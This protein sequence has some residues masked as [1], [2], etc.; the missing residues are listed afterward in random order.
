ML[1]GYSSR[2]APALLLGLWF[3]MEVSHAF[4][5]EMKIVT[6]ADNCRAI[7][8]AAGGQ[9]RIELPQAGA[10]GYAWEIQDLDSEYFEL[11][12]AGTTGRPSP[13]DLV[14][15]PVTMQW[16]LLVKKTGRAEL[17]LLQYRPWEGK[18]SAI[19]TFVL[20]VEIY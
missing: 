10:A 20:E 3:L 11:L 17:R 1:R 15:A 8:V 5:A 2:K 14:G 4:G 6:Q 9:L 13:Q 16:T 18:A 19:E 12:E 7:K